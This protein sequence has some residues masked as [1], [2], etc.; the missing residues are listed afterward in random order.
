VQGTPLGETK[1]LRGLAL[2]LDQSFASALTLHSIEHHFVPS[3]PLFAQKTLNDVWMLKRISHG[4][5]E[6]HKQR[7]ERLAAASAER[8]AFEKQQS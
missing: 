4:F 7:P 6:D 5:H 8:E 2:E 1:R 3:K